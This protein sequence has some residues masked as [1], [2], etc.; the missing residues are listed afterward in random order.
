MLDGNPQC[1]V[2]VNCGS[3]L[4][5]NITFIFDPVWWNYP[6]KVFDNSIGTWATDYALAVFMVY[7]TAFLRLRDAERKHILISSSEFGIHSRN[8]TACVIL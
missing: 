3:T 7:Q 5:E 6:Y 8:G 1:G 4:L 2:E